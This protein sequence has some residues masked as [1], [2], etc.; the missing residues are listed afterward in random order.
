MQA[1]EGFAAVQNRLQMRGSVKTHNAQKGSKGAVGTPRAGQEGA[2]RRKM[3]AGE[4]RE[5]H[6]RQAKRS[7]ASR[8]EQ[9]EAGKR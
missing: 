6:G 8:E 5:S 7:R 4:R 1:Y 9:R 2:G 3:G